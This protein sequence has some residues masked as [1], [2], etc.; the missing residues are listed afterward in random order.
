M[1]RLSQKPKNL[2]REHLEA[3]HTSSELTRWFRRVR[4][5]NVEKVTV[6]RIIAV[7]YREGINPVLMGTH[8]LIGYRSEPRATQDVD[9]LV[10]KKD[11]RKAARVLNEE[12]PYLEVRDSSV[13]MR[14]VDPVSQKVVI[15]VMKPTS[16]TMRM[17]FRHSLKIGKTHRIPA[18]EMA[19]ICKF[20]AMT[21]PNRREDKRLIDLGDFVNVVMNNR[22]TLDLEKLE[23]IGNLMNPR[24][25]SA[26]L[27]IVEDIDAGR[28]VHL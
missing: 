26:I 8:G 10:T 23:R 28:R 25:G 3:L 27:R 2:V 16:Q 1:I 9:V 19:L 13:V 6:E 11:V 21:A 7:L 18:L 15:D 4:E 20:D 17:V 22:S 12:Y 24:R 5:P 14:F